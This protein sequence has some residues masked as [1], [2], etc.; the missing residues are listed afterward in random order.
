MIE[1]QDPEVLARSIPLRRIGLRDDV[2]RLTLW[3]ASDESAYASGADFVIDG[4]M[5]A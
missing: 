2:A 4:G 1:G 5:K 3:L